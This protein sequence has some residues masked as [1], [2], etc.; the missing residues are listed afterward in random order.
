MAMIYSIDGT[1]RPRVKHGD[2]FFSTGDEFLSDGIRTFEALWASDGHAF[3]THNGIICN[4]FGRTFEMQPE[5]GVHRPDIWTRGDP[6]LIVRHEC[7]SRRTF[8]RAYPRL[9][10][11]YGHRRYPQERLLLH[12]AGPLARIPT[13]LLVCSELAAKL[14][15]DVELLPGYLGWSPDALADHVCWGGS[16]WQIV[17]FGM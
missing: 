9:L 15:Y 8:M 4:A 11:D 17:Y 13:G 3:W 7:M 5:G 12:A 14:F 10:S 2:L 6:L 16:Q 1:P